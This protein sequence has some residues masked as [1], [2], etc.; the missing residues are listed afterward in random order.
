M[1][2]LTVHYRPY[3]VD[4]K[5]RRRGTELATRHHMPSFNIPCMLHVAS[6]YSL[7]RDW[8]L[9]D[10]CCAV[11]PVTRLNSLEIC[12]S[13]CPFC[14]VVQVNLRLGCFKGTIH[15]GLSIK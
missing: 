5:M 6:Q 15:Y 3:T 12:T 10:S 14:N 4:G 8:S 2:T 13:S 1:S 9:S 7:I 11:F